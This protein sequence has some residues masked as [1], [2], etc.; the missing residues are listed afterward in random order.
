MFQKPLRRK[1]GQRNGLSV[2]INILPLISALLGA[3]VYS[4]VMMVQ[5]LRI[6]LEKGKHQLSVKIEVTRKADD[7]GRRYCLGENLKINEVRIKVKQKG[8]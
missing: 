2:K 7:P 6:M 1:E 4:T 3:F 5:R 8:L